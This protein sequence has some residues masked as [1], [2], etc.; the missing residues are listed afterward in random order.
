VSPRVFAAAAGNQQTL[1]VASNGQIGFAVWLDQRR[2]AYDLY[3]SRIDPSG[4]SLDPLGILIANGATGGTVIWNGTEFV[5]LSE[6]GSDKMF[7]FVTPEGTITARKSL[8]LLY[9]QFVASLGSGPD[10]RLL[11]VGLG[12]ATIVDSAGNVV[13][14]NVQTGM[15]ASDSLRVAGGTSEFLILHTMLVP[16]S[17]LYAERIDRD[18]RLLASAVD[19]GL[20]VNVTGTALALT[21]EDDD[22]L[23][24]GRGVTNR[25]VFGVHLG[26]NGVA[27]GPIKR[28]EPFDSS[29]RVSFPDAK[30]AVLRD[31]DGYDVAWTTSE[32]NGSAHTSVMRESASDTP[33]R[34]LEWTGMG[35]RTTLAKIGSH[36]AVVTDALRSGV[37]TSID[38]I[39]TILEPSL[40][41][42][43]QPF[44]LA[45]T[46]TRQATPQIAAATSGYAV[47]WNEYGP[48][49]ATHLYLRRYLSAPLP[50]T[51]TPV[52]IA[53]D[54][55]GH[56]IDARI[57]ASGDV[58]IIAWVTST[59][60]SG[61][62][63]YVFRRISATTGAWLDPEPVP[64]ATAQ[65]LVLSGNADGALALYTIDCSSERCLRARAI[66]TDAGSPLRTAETAPSNGRA[67]QLSLAGNG[68]DYLAAWND[69]VC[70][71]PCDVPFPSRIVAQRMR[72]D[73]SAVDA[74]PIILDDTALSFPSNPS[75]AWDG[76]RYAVSWT[77]DASILGTH[78]S[79]GGVSEGAREIYRRPSQ[80]LL[81][82]LVA[83]AGS[84]LLFL[85]TVT[86]ST[87]S[88]S[89]IAVD[90][91]SLVSIGEFDPVA[92]GQP[93]SATM[94]VAGTPAGGL[95][96]A[97]DRIDDAGGN[98]PR[99]FTRFLTSP[100]RRRAA[101]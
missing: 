36:L 75:V 55:N 16:G 14:S 71:F 42:G 61:S 101:R 92:I 2:G 28:F 52:E 69:N 41:S 47:L 84:L 37:S 78:I 58:Y 97:Y 48:D 99:V 72:E 24:A 43:S 100:P 8:L 7:T 29:Y 5:V 46:A 33:T 89:V 63:N 54:A 11:F 65:E 1:A 80:L 67:Y 86:A 40:D 30:P 49:G 25:E 88:T 51:V 10:A 79:A 35:Y 70:Y 76:G 17:H 15:P 64:L 87:S 73:G 59:N 94:S 34:P 9:H 62:G 22:Y 12:R 26:R 13:V 6:S 82:K 39:A 23:L 50:G 20:D 68:H 93:V 45:S 83:N 95:A 18:G 44:V 81:Q 60:L 85:T 21:G 96:L 56:R 74:K 31:G 57:A 90:P 66:A 27:K 38:S 32:A 53:T 77:R 3:G 91:Q 4:I 98:V 19:T